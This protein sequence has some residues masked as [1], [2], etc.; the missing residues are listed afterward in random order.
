MRHASWCEGV[1]RTCLLGV[2]DDLAP[3]VH[4]SGVAVEHLQQ[5]LALEH[6][7]AHRRNERLFSRLLWSASED[8]R[9]HL[10]STSW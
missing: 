8:C 7:D 6:V 5:R 4:V 2:W 10:H 1:Q 9:V 3:K